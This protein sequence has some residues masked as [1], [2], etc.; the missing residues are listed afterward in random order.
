M[1]RFSIN[2]AQSDSPSMPVRWRNHA[3]HRSAALCTTAHLRVTFARGSASSRATVRG[4]CPS[5]H[6]EHRQLQQQRLAEPQLPLR[7]RAPSPAACSLMDRVPTRGILRRNDDRTGRCLVLRAAVADRVGCAGRGRRAAD[8]AAAGGE[9]GHRPWRPRR[10]AGPV[11][12]HHAKPEDA[13]VDRP[14][15]GRRGLLGTRGPLDTWDTRGTR[16]TAWALPR[17]LEHAAATFRVG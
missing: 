5:H 6:A 15:V 9:R 17:G 4:Y 11:D 16:G 13:R 3:Q 14:Q 7:P 1:E 8:A 2:L 10:R 12:V